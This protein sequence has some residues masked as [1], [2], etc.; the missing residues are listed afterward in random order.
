MTT[1]VEVEN[2]TKSYRSLPSATDG[3]L[4]YILLNCLNRAQ[5][6]THTTMQGLQKKTGGVFDWSVIVSKWKIQ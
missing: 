3:S 2:A 1:Q 4:I 5:R 6:S